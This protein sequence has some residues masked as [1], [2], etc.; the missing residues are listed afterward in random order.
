VAVCVLTA[1]LFSS[2]H[3]A[4]DVIIKAILLVMIVI[5]PGGCGAGL[6]S[7]VQFSAVRVNVTV[8]KLLS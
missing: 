4:G 5:S 1:M 6:G 3:T 8:L 7:G 2:E